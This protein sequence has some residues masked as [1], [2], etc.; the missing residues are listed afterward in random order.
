MHCSEL[1]VFIWSKISAYNN[2]AIEKIIIYFLHIF[3]MFDYFMEYSVESRRLLR[4][5]YIEQ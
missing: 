2:S 5:A 3:V 1:S 4:G